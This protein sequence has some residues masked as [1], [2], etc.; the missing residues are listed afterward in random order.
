MYIRPQRNKTGVT[1][2]V[3]VGA[4]NW[5]SDSRASR[6][7]SPGMNWSGYLK[8]WSEAATSKTGGT[9]RRFIHATAP[10]IV[11]HKPHPGNIVKMYLLVDVLQAVTDEGLL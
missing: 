3:L 11:L 5:L 6:K 9:R 4:I 1:R 8:G 10:T 2:A 7:I